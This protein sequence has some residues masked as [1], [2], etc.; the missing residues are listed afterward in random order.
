MLPNPVAYLVHR[1][2]AHPVLPAGKAYAYV[3][4]GNGLFKHA[5]NRHIDALIPLATARVA[6]LSPLI[7]YVRLRAGRIPGQLLHRVLADARRQSWD[8]PREAMYHITIQNNQVRVFRPS[9]RAS[10]ASLAYAGGSDPD[11]VLDLH[12]HQEMHAFFS[13][14]DTRDEQGFRFY[15]V[16]GR[17]FT[18]PEIRLRL[19]MYGD[20]Y[21]VPLTSVFTNEGGNR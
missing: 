16:I 3:V 6:G 15:A 20:F 4:A 5:I 12:S 18:H 11:I 19:G 7:P 17:I 9:Q 1:N 8:R 2:G 10:A 13:G 14:T 21:R